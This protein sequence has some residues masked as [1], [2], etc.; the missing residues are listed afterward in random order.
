MAADVLKRSRAILLVATL[1]V[2]LPA[3]AQSGSGAG[4]S[5]R[6]DTQGGRIP[7][8]C[9]GATTAVRPNDCPADGG[10]SD[11][12]VVILP[13]ILVDLFDWPAG[14]NSST[15]DDR[16]GGSGG[17]SGDPPVPTPN[18]ESGSQSAGPTAKPARQQSAGGAAP[19]APPTIPPPFASRAPLVPF[20][21]VSGDFVADEVLA[22]VD[23]DAQSVQEIAA[24]FGLEIRA[25]RLSTLLGVTI[26]RLGIPDGRPVGLV[27]A[28]LAGDQRVLQREANHVLV[29]QQAAAVVNYAFQRIVLDADTASGEGVRVAVIDTAVDENHP[30]LKG[31][32]AATF[33][34]LPETPVEERDHGTSIDGLIAGTGPFPGM[35]PGAVIYHARAFEGGRSTMDV[36]L[37][38]LDWAAEQDVRIINMS[39]VGPR[40]GLLE[41]ACTAARTRG[42][43]LVAAAGNNGP[44]A[45]YGYPAAYEGVIAVT[46]TDE[47]DRLMPQANRGP[48]VF[49][50]APGVDM[51]APVRGGND[52][53]TGTSFAAAVVTGAVANL[54]HAAPDRTVDWVEAALSETA[55]DLGD[56]GRDN[57]FGF[58]LMN[59][60]AASDRQK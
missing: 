2:P 50:S 39:F 4:S 13:E 34:A 14:D 37:A 11:G 32:I 40:N 55:S 27:L 7:P 3:F 23:G 25:Q 1:L 46:A 45:P 51:I 31:V 17:V 35:A 36:L 19:P 21:A 12:L 49:I 52:L 48:Y 29:L 16:P 42:M 20:Q 44:K 56:R 33:D 59:A 58:G 6:E 41:I 54:L 15:G 53:V 18:P 28:Q 24:A 43:I 38:A 57:D 60:K 47:K 30:A 9:D 10:R 26:A 8:G 5:T 22:T